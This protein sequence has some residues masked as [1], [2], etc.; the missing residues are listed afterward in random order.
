MKKSTLRML[1]KHGLA[2]CRRAWTLS[3]QG[4]GPSNIGFY[5]GVPFWTA[6]GLINAGENIAKIESGGI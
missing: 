2:L 4:E 6:N 1:E 5:L 3:C